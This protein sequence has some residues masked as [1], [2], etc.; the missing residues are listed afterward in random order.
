GPERKVA[1]AHPFR[2][3]TVDADSQLSRGISL[4][5]DLDGTGGNSHLL[6]FRQAEDVPAGRA[7]E[8]VP[9]RDLSPIAHDGLPDEIRDQPVDGLKITFPEPQPVRQCT[10]AEL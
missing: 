7:V 8:D 2:P 1:G 6:F 9:E 10:L 5:G 3:G 4:S